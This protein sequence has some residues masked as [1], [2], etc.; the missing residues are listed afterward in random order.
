MGQSPTK[1]KQAQPT[2]S[3]AK[4]SYGEKRELA[5]L[6]EVLETL[7]KE[8]DELEAR[9]PELYRSEPGEIK[10]LTR[11]WSCSSEIAEKI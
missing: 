8:R 2:T 4:L 1:Q 9:G 3:V 5:E 11:Q 10:Q 7:E 6:P